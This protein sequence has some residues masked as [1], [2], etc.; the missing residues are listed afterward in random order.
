MDEA[1]RYSSDAA[2]SKTGRQELAVDFAGSI[3]AAGSYEERRATPYESVFTSETGLL[4]QEA[5]DDVYRFVR[6]R[7]RFKRMD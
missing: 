7:R 6:F 1:A 2:I 4:M 3:L 5:R